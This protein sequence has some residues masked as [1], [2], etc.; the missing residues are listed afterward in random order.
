MVSVTKKKRDQFWELAWL[1]NLIKYA[2]IMNIITVLKEMILYNVLQNYK[3]ERQLVQQS[4]FCKIFETYPELLSVDLFS[5]IYTSSMGK[6][7]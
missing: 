3:S 2:C 6:H 7:G 5:V 1:M 4:D